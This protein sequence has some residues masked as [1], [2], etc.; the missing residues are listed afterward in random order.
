[1]NDRFIGI[2]AAAL[3]VFGFRGRGFRIGKGFV[4]VV[5][6]KHT[7]NIVPCPGPG[8]ERARVFTFVGPTPHVPPGID[9]SDAS[10]T[11]GSAD[12][13]SERWR[14]R[15]A[16]QDGVTWSLSYEFVSGLVLLS[17]EANLDSLDTVT[18]NQWLETFFQKVRELNEQLAEGW[19]TDV[20]LPSHGDA[21]PAASRIIPGASGPYASIH[22]EAMN[23]GD[24]S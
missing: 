18:L 7:V 8:P 23:P 13:A 16:D 15:H 4:L 6:D 21:M 17:T 10:S 22:V 1:M 3:D 14:T 9:V 11:S 20:L 24:P 12:S 5:D 19:R 2:V